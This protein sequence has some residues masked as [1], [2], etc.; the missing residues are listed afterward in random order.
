[1]PSVVRSPPIRTSRFIG[2]RVPSASRPKVWTSR[3]QASWEMRIDGLLMASVPASAKYRRPEP[4]GSVFQVPT[5]E[6]P[7]WVG[8]V[9]QAASPR[10]SRA[11]LRARAEGTDRFIAGRPATQGAVGEGGEERTKRQTIVSMRSAGS[12]RTPPGTPLPGPSRAQRCP[13][14]K[15]QR[16]RRPAPWRGLLRRSDLPAATSPSGLV[17]SGTRSRSVMEAGRATSV[18]RSWPCPVEPESARRPVHGP[19]SEGSWAPRG[20]LRRLGARPCERCRSHIPIRD[21]PQ[22]AG[23][24]SRPGVR[25]TQARTRA[26]RQPPRPR[27]TRGDPGGPS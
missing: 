17:L 22:A 26:V 9:E 21:A 27:R 4:L 13:N 7:P 19:S 12:R 24:P 16:G 2:T 5:A 25:S 23:T 18:P 14:P 15:V 20:R 8:S 1:M 3:P 10:T 11:A 6:P